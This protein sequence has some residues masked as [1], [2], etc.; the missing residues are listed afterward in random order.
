MTAALHWRAVVVIADPLTRYPLTIG[1]YPL[2]PVA[3]AAAARAAGAGEWH[4]IPTV[5]EVAA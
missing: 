1:T 5:V 3:A 2:W 4:V